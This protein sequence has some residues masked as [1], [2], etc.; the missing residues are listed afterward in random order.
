MQDQLKALIERHCH[1]IR[2]T[3]E[4]VGINLEL[5]CGTPGGRLNS[6][7]EAESLTHQLKGSSGSLGFP[8]VSITAS[9]LNEHLKHLCAAG[10]ALSGPEKDRLFVLYEALKSTTTTVSPDNSN[11]YPRTSSTSIPLAQ[12]RIVS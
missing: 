10:R 11:L 2:M 12:S 9:A 1:T 6:L 8:H 7:V 5:G 4:T 3:V